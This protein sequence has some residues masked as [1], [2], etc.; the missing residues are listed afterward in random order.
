MDY[1]ESLIITKYIKGKFFYAF[2][3]DIAHK[4]NQDYNKNQ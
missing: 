2:K 4:N 3:F 1:C